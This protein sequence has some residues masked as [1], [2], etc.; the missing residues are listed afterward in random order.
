MANIRIYSNMDTVKITQVSIQDK[1][2]DGTALVTKKGEKFWKVGI[3]TDKFGDDWFSAL[4]FKPDDAVMNL[5]QGDEVEI[6]IEQNGEFKN[7][8]LPS[9]LD[10]LETRLALVEGKVKLLLHEEKVV[11]K[12]LNEEDSDLPF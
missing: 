9:R 6:I 3:K 1:K 8:K 12:K 10:K 11:E 5:Q 4:A 2:K 7:F